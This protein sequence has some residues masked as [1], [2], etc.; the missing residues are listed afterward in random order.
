ECRTGRPRAVPAPGRRPA[1]R[2]PTS[3]WAMSKRTA[4]TPGNTGRPPT[5]TAPRPAGSGR[6]ERRLGSATG[7]Q[8]HA[9]GAFDD[10]TGHEAVGGGHEH[11]LGHL[12]RVP[13][14]TDR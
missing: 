5:P 12:V 1:G 2:A 14:A 6:S 10:G 7:G 13:D 8:V 9:A 4:A 3:G 11:R